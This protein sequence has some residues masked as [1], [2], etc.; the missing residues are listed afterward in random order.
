MKKYFHASIS[1]AILEQ[2]P[3]DISEMNQNIWRMFF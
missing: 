1:D 2:G 3:E